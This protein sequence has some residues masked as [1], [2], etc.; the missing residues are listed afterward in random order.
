MISSSPSGVQN[1][2]DNFQ[3][4]KYSRQSQIKINIKILQSSTY[5]IEEDSFSLE[6]I[7]WNMRRS[8]RNVSIQWFIWFIDFTMSI[9]PTG[10]TITLVI[11][12][13]NSWFV[14]RNCVNNALGFSENI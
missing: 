3:K 11:P 14:Y 12:I 2:K 10:I 4:G 6:R 8:W 9:S 5:L 13:M 1:G 7:V